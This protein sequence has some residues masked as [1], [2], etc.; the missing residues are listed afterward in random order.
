LRIDDIY[1][2]N[3]ELHGEKTK[4]A[5]PLNNEEISFIGL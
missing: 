1:L 3:S 5:N 2:T 4:E